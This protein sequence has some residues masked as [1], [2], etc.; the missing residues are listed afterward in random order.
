[1]EIYIADVGVE[2][3]TWLAEEFNAPNDNRGFRHS[4][5]GRVEI[6]EE[7][8][9]VLSQLASHEDGSLSG[10]RSGTAYIWIAGEHFPLRIKE[11]S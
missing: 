10:D 9:A 1:M 3:A 11:Q 6:D 4:G 8:L 2:N 7:G 5:N